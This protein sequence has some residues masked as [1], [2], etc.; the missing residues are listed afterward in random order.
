M[1]LLLVAVAA[2]AFNALPTHALY[3]KQDK[4]IQLNQL[5][6]QSK[7]LKS[8]DVWMVE[9]FAPWCGHCK[10]LAPTYKKL[11]EKMQ[12]IVRIGAVDCDE[13]QSICGQQGVKGF[14]TIKIFLGDKT[15]SQKKSTDYQGARSLKP[16]ADYAV[17]LIPDKYVTRLKQAQEFGEK[18][19]IRIVLYWNGCR[20]RFQG[21][22]R[23]L[24][25][26]DK[27]LVPP[28]FKSLA[29]SYKNDFSF[30]IA[31][32]SDPFA[33]QKLEGVKAPAVLLFA[34]DSDGYVKFEGTFT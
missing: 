29:L 13:N 6:F 22:P 18:V 33:K 10:N 16:M 32:P 17:S 25:L 2:F 11:A 31:K 34:D 14:P 28:L 4:V 7:V 15:G 8:P 3:T 19:F 24:L 23:V 27:S 12:G 1:K 20:T 30:G 5:N 26:S 9:F 21:K